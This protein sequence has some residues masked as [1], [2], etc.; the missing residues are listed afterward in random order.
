MEALREIARPLPLTETVIRAL[1]TL[2]RDG[3][4]G[5]GD[6]LPTERALAERFGV[7]RAVVREAIACLKADGHVVTRQGAGAYVAARPAL[8]SFKLAR[9]DQPD[10]HE[11]AH[12]FELRLSVESTAAELAALRRTSQDLE[13]LDAS[14]SAMDRALAGQGDGSEADNAF[15]R[16]IAVAAHNP[17]LERLIALIGPPFA[18]SRRPTWSEP[19]LAEAAQAEHRRLFQAI[20]AGDP[21]AARDAARNHLLRAAA[22]L[23]L[24]VMERTPPRGPLSEPAEPPAGEG[25]NPE[26]IQPRA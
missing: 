5:P 19:S 13:K 11:L 26:K 10:P 22:R 4:F 15:H 6:R 14:L 21:G 16:A 17:Y 1:Q 8:L 25:E 24:A 2:I 9:H 3:A 18:D 12:I 23:G 7:S 20:A